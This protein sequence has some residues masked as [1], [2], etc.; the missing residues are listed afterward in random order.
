[1]KNLGMS[2]AGR[3][4]MKNIV[5]SKESCLKIN[6]LIKQPNAVHNNSTAFLIK[7]EE[8]TMTHEIKEI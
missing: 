2:F 8:G 3:S 7:R 4:P 1:M 5:N 6:N